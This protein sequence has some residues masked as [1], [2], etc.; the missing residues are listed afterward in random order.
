MSL[1]T[2]ESSLGH[3]L[4]LPDLTSPSWGI[5]QTV[6][7]LLGILSLSLSYSLLS[8]SLTLSSLKNK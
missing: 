8:L 3:D 1:E 5:L 7:S 4:T 6:W 2:L